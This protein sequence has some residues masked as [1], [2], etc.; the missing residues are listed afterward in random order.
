M[1]IICFISPYYLNYII[2]IKEING[3]ISLYYLNYII[4]IKEINGFVVT[5]C[6]V[7]SRLRRLRAGC[8]QFVR[9]LP[10]KKIRHTVTSE[11]DDKMSETMIKIKIYRILTC[12]NHFSILAHD[13]THP[14]SNISPSPIF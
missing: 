11:K 10:V 2:G 13:T 6:A 9:S 4:D 14:P 1:Y 3:F 12:L 5:K 7:Y 8:A